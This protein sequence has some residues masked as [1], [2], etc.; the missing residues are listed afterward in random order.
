[1]WGRAM[2]KS[3]PHI[4]NWPNYGIRTRTQQRKLVRASF[5]G[6]VC[7]L[8]HH[9]HK[10]QVICSI[11]FHDITDLHA[12]ETFIALNEAVTVLTNADSRATYDRRLNQSGIQEAI[13]SRKRKLAR[14]Y[15]VNEQKVVRET[16][17]RKKASSHLFDEAKIRQEWAQYSEA[18][19][20]HVK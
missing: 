15:K 11:I 20:N 4:E 2:K 5:S 17:I 9:V 7:S 13:D 14:D 3:S 12:E 16:A 1:M 10:I 19:G 8:F 18:K 6:F